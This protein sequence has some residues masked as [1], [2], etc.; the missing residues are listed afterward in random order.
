MESEVDPSCLTLWDP[1]HGFS[2]QKYWNGFP[3]PSPGNLPTQGLN[4]GLLHFRQTLYHLSHQG[5]NRSWGTREAINRSWDSYYSVFMKVSQ[6][7]Y[8]EVNFEGSLRLRHIVGRRSILGWKKKLRTVPKRISAKRKKEIV[9][10]G[11]ILENI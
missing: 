11:I 9:K 2:R 10:K 5:S 1:V 4:S 3:F 7:N 8:I 6:R